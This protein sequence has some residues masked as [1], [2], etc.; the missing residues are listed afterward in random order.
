M[1]EAFDDV[2]WITKTGCYRAK[3]TLDDGA[4]DT[5]IVCAISGGPAMGLLEALP[6]YVG[7]FKAFLGADTPEDMADALT[8][9]L[10]DGELAGAL[11]GHIDAIIASSLITW[12]VPGLETI[13]WLTPDLSK[14]PPNALMDADERAAIL[15]SVPV[16]VIVRLVVG[17]LWLVKN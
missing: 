16:P 14:H 5:A 17:A 13:P 12:S 8:T 4:D 11:W 3:I 15:K 7:Q 10:Q 9:A 1:L 6:R 2:K